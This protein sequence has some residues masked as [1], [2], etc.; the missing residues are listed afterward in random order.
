M[1]KP[2]PLVAAGLVLISTAAMLATNLAVPLP[3]SAHE[4]HGT[5]SAGQPGDPK[6]PARVIKVKMFEGSGKMGYEPARIEVRR[7]EQVRFVLQNDGEED[8]E[9]V[10]ATVTENRKHAEVMKKN[11]DMEHDDPNAKRLQ[12]HGSSEIVWKFTKRG[13]FEFAC[14]IPGHYEKGMVGRIIVK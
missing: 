10:L 1:P 12:P 6:K 9:F 8:H 4:D 5:F 14:L 3:A 2:T 13:E 7:G 11:P